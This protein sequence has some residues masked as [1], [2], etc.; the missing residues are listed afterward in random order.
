[1]TFQVAAQDGDY[2]TQRL[3]YALV[4][5]APTGA[6]VTAAG[7]F[8]WTPADNQGPGTSVIAV[9]VTDNGTPALSATQDVV[10]VVNELYLQGSAQAAG[11]YLDEPT[12][13]IDK[14]ARSITVDRPSSNTCFYRLRCN[15]PVRITRLR[16]IGNQVLI[17]YQFL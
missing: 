9:R 11:P 4:P 16:L 6:E 14:T 10:V 7:I 3:T 5:G 8:S 13:V 1:L 17:D 12:A 2:P 15:L